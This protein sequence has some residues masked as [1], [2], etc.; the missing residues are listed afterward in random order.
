MG[1][2]NAKEV[3]K[4]I[5][6]DKFGFIGTFM[7]WTLMKMLKIDTMN[8]IYDRNKHLNDLEFINALL[9]EFEINFEIPEEDL[10]RIPKN[11][12][13][14]TISNHPLGGIDGILLLKLLLEH[15]SDFKIIANFLL[16]RILP[17]KPY[18][19]PVN[20]F[21][22]RK[23]VKS[24]VMGFKNALSHLKD[25][26]PLGIFPAGEVST[27]RDGKLVV[28]KPWEVAAMKLIKKAEVPVLPIYFHAKNSKMFYRM[29]KFNDTFRTAKLP[30]ELLT[31]KER[32][33]K[34]RIGNP[35]SVSDQAE[36]EGLDEFTEFLRKKTYVLANPF[37]KKKRLENIPK[38][39]KIPK[40][41]KKIAG[42]VSIEMMETEIE[43]LRR[44]DK[45][46]LQSKNYEV[47][48]A[49]AQL[50]PNILQ[51]IGRLREITF[52][53][54]GEGTNNPTDLDKFDSYYHHM[55]LWDGDA[56]KIVGAY[57]M[58]LGSKI[59]PQFGID[60]FYLQDLF[61]FESELYPMMEQSIEMGRAFIIN[62]YQQRPMPLF[63]LWKGIVHTTLRFPEHKF[64]I[65]GVSISNK[66]SEFSKSL[67]IEFMKSNYY[68]PYVA[69][70]IN[71]KKEFKVKLKD[72][73]KDFIF[74]E[75]EAD[76]NKF[77][78]LIDEVEPGS[79]RLPVL[80]K[81][82]IKQNAKV[83]AFNVDPMFNNAVDG[84]MYIR[85]ADLPESTVKP[86]MEEFQ[87]E[88]EKKYLSK[89]EEE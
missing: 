88:L 15:R 78:K 23:D 5:N 87:A 83:V 69:Q 4:A 89:D 65:G 18:V 63:L 40:A 76:L 42:A 62:E 14:I 29:A 13:F 12:S 7:G 85:I 2:V 52:R 86:V 67:M 30:S 38:T 82:Y 33:I 81:K 24:S 17:L 19:M 43:L 35:I 39:L 36:H 32:L 54:V 80:I 47:F 3:A 68:D 8:K 37:Q 11:G 21:E 6:V 16:H 77:D 31:Q 84:L 79:L 55:F 53:E 73:D 75:T 70:Y 26:H 34:V 56:K 41:P 60:G 59:F 64:L 71:P 50:I 72:A 46:L 25:G 49:P 58:G 22:D 61:R 45:R 57:R 9:D 27:Y 44:E 51:E 66:F 20:P 1:L 28:D 74:D 10:K 48:L